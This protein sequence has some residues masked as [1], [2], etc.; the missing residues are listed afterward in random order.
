MLRI[1]YPCGHKLLNFLLLKIVKNVSTRDP[2]SA[3]FL[4]KNYACA[5]TKTKKTEAVQSFLD[6]VTSRRV[7][8]RLAD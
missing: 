4:L 2:G 7:E 6:F 8:L 3:I 1:L 5:F